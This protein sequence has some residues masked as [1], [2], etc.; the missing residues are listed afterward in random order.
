VKVPELIGPPFGHLLWRLRRK[1]GLTQRELASKSGVS[2]RAIS[3]LERGVSQ[4]A[5]AETA[6][7]LAAGLGLAGPDRALFE[8]AARGPEPAE[9]AALP[10]PGG[11]PR[12]LPRDIASFT[13]RGP[14]LRELL[15]M[16]AGAGGTVAIKAIDGMAGIGKTALAVHAAHRLAGRYRDGQI[17]LPLHG[18]TPGQR[19]VRPADGLASLL[20]SAG[21]PPHQIGEGLEARMALWRGWAAGKQLLLVFDDVVSSEQVRPLLPGTAGSLVLVTS[22]RHLTA[23]EDAQVIRLDS[24]P[25]DE[26]AL[27]LSRLAG[28][29]GLDRGD[30]AIAE[31]TA[32]CGNLPLAIGMLG[33]QLYHHPAWAPAQAAGY[34]AAARNR[35]D[36]M[37]TENLSVAAAFDRSYRDLSLGGQRLFRRLGLHPGTGIDAWAAS[38]LDGTDPETARM[39]LDA[40]YDQSL[41]TEPA[42]GRYGMHDLIRRHAQDLVTADPA[43]DRHQALERL[44]DYY[45]HTA[46]R[47]DTRLARRTR[48]VP[49]ATAVAML[50]GPALADEGQALAWARA[51]RI[52]LLGCLDYA[53]GTGQHARVSALTAVLAELL[54]RDGPWA[55][56]IARHTVAIAAAQHLGDRSGQAG[57]LSNLGIVRRAT[58][59]Y[60][61]A[62]HALER[63]LNIY[64]ALG[65]QLGQANALNDLGAVRHLTS[66]HPGAAQALE[67]ALNIYRALGEQLGQASALNNL[68]NVRRETGDY[69]GTAQSLEQALSIYR[70]L[71]DQLGQ[72]NALNNLGIVRRLTGDYPGAAQALEQALNMYR[73][74]GDQY[75]QASARHGLGNV[76]RLTGDYLGAAQ[77]LEQ[78]LSISR[79]LGDR[80]GEAGALHDL[81]A[82]LRLTG[83]Y[84]GAA[85]ALEQALSICRD[86]GNRNGEAEILNDR[87]MLHLVCGELGQAGRCHQQ[88]LELARAISSSRDEAHALAGLG[89]CAAAAGHTTR[90]QALLG[91]AHTI[92]RRIGAADT[93]AILAPAPTA[94]PRAE[95]S[96]NTEEPGPV[97]DLPPSVDSFP[98]V[99]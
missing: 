80:N 6:R 94:K 17:F 10:V 87:G 68:G 79:S 89:H 72:A 4:N 32:L 28:R 91:Q 36:T 49:P 7:L 63:S 86:L 33:R 14:Y 3:D 47:A 25:A 61:R 30:P 97:A 76:R 73:A 27:L 8:A 40:L 62:A 46:A 66:D 2:E 42:P 93:P 21:V 75:G 50:P 15:D 92:F 77:A 52:N 98:A 22:R 48:P 85:Q 58:G 60:S 90:A 23:L 5:R 74:L 45:Q 41:L 19:P 95:V 35:L 67:Q 20:L 1:A 69:P 44:M 39:L 38:A 34:L 11:P 31:I 16:A 29:P 78:A 99:P 54:R 96:T 82:A 13:G 83:D 18:H 84:P 12:T 9:G 65:D 37:K 26:A 43:T 81:G 88:A 57:A 64:R 51:E 71:G 56:A 24:L 59:D 53:T 70:A 55:D